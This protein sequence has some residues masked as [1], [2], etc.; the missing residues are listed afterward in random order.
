MGSSYW[1]RNPDGPFAVL[2]AVIVRY[3]SL[4]AGQEDRTMQRLSRRQC[5]P[6]SLSCSRRNWC[7]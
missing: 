1:V 2:A 7:A 3:A 4:A 5:S 6:N